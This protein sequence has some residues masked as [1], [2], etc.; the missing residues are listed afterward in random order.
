[1]ILLLAVVLLSVAYFIAILV[2]ATIVRVNRLQHQTH[3]NRNPIRSFDCFFCTPDDAPPQVFHHGEPLYA[4]ALADIREARHSIMLEYYIFDDD[5]IGRSFA[6]EMVARAEQGVDVRIIVDGYGCRRSRKLLNDMAVSGIKV[7]VYRPMLTLSVNCRNHKKIIITDRKVAYVGGINIADR[8]RRMTQTGF[9]RDTHLRMTGP[10]VAELERVFRA[11]WLLADN[12]G[13]ATPEPRLSPRGGIRIVS[14]HFGLRQTFIEII[15]C[16]EREIL[17]STPYFI[18]PALLFDVLKSAV[19]RGVSVKVL[20]PQHSDSRVAGWS[21][22]SYV[23]EMMA[24]G[25]EVWRYGAGFNH[26]KVLIADGRV[27]IAGSANFD[28]RSFDCNEEIAVVV[29]TKSTVEALRLDFNKALARSRKTDPKMWNRR[30]MIHRMAEKFS[31]P[32]HP[33]L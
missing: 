5:N 8:Y 31:E 17:L 12:R 4:A 16:A 29:P 25:M 26:S 1:M 21:T 14:D 28:N 10:E 3:D 30:P 33:L 18:P 6:R 27:A 11:D 2:V 13:F 15:G 23:G 20:L 7:A 32:L 22:D 9:W 19:G 24:S